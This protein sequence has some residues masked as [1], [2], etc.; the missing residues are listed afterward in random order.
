MQEV[1]L[2]V[3]VSDLAAFS[4]ARRQWEQAVSTP[5]ECMAG[6]QGLGFSLPPASWSRLSR[7][8]VA[9]VAI[10]HWP[11]RCTSLLKRGSCL[12]LVPLPVCCKQVPD[13]LFG[14]SNSFFDFDRIREAI[15]VIT[16]EDFL[17]TVAAQGLLSKPLPTD[18]TIKVCLRKVVEGVTGGLAAYS[19]LCPLQLL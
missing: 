16:M 3:Q 7:R 10:C 5:W 15:D 4:S 19:L 13:A 12:T 8:Q 11:V 18:V 2:A 14:G 17:A 9:Q 6:S 1:P